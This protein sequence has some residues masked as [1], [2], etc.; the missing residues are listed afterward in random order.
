M[1]ALFYLEEILKPMLE[2]IVE[3][4]NINPGEDITLLEECDILK[5]Y[6]QFVEIVRD[7]VS[8]GLEN[9]IAR[10][11]EQCIGEHILERFLISRKIW[12]DE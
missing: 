8:Q 2:L 3:I 1:Q 4:R 10:A 7:N 9:P 6:T 5:E 11:I 12:S